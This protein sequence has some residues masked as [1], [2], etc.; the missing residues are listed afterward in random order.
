[1]LEIGVR[2]G[3]LGFLALK[4]GK[5]AVK[6]DVLDHLAIF[7]ALLLESLVVSL[8]GA[9]RASRCS[10]RGAEEDAIPAGNDIDLGR[11]YGFFVFTGAEEA[12][13]YIWNVFLSGC[14]W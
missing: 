14:A 13:V 10:D 7:H 8:D 3:E 6:V 4:P 1:M 12:V 11:G 5:L 2:G 9:R